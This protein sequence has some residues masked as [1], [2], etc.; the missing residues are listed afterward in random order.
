MLPEEIKHKLAT[1][2]RPG[3][4]PRV[5]PAVPGARSKFG[6]LPLLKADESWPCCGHCH[7]PMQLFVQLDSQDL[8][9]DARTGFGDGVL[10]VFYCTNG[11]ED[12]EV[13]G[14]AH[15][16]F[17]DASLVRMIPRQ[18]ADGFDALPVGIPD[19]F[20]EQA[21]SGWQCMVDFPDRQETVAINED[22]PDG[23]VALL[24]AHRPA[25]HAG[26]KFLGW[27]HWVTDVDYPSC[28]CCNKPMRFIFQIDSTDTLPFWF[29]N[30]GC[31]YV[32]QC[33]SNP[34]V[35]TMSWDS[36]P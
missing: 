32:F 30:S 17:S 13:L 10:Q 12:C 3:W 11:E 21:L 23:M 8:P 1:L 4:R 33:E 6:G 27:P 2:S 5:G 18:Q 20:V 19:A 29:G 31:A 34:Q 24:Q 35:L 16:P 25:P 22:V 14:H 28:S 15:L 36:R 26:D 9:V 7:Q